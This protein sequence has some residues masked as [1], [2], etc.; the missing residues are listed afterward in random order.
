MRSAAHAR[1]IAV[2]ASTASPMPSTGKRLVNA[3]SEWQSWSQYANWAPDCSG[4]GRM[5]NAGSQTVFVL[6]RSDLSSHCMSTIF[7]DLQ[8]RAAGHEPC[9]YHMQSCTLCGSHS[10]DCCHANSALPRLSSVL[11]CAHLPLVLTTM[12]FA[13]T[14]AGHDC[15]LKYPVLAPGL[16]QRHRMGDGIGITKCCKGLKHAGIRGTISIAVIGL[17]LVK[18]SVQKRNTTQCW[19]RSISSHAS[20]A[21][22]FV[23]PV[24]GLVARHHDWHWDCRRSQASAI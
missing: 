22:S 19:L 21:A 14:Y 15:V 7:C 4:P 11:C 13:L 3:D 16:Q 12:A 23:P 20:S 18:A 8:P 9:S 17:Q 1:A 24:W 10:V 2:M 5:R 6:A